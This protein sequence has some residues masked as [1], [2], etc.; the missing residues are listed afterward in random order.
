MNRRHDLV[1]LT[2]AGWHAAVTADPGHDGA[3]RDW[4][5][6]DWPAVVRRQDASAGDAVV[7]LGIPLPISSGVRQRLSLVA[8]VDHIARRTAPVTL[9]DALAAAP[10][11]W[12]AGLVALARDAAGL[13]LR[14]Y[15]SLAMESVTGAP[16]LRPES[17]ID[18]L[19]RPST[20]TELR[21]GLALLAHHAALLPLDGEIV[22]PSGDAVAWKE[23]LAARRDQARVLV[24]S[25]HAVRLQDPALL[26][27]SLPP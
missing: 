2:R 22:F 6:N 20:R 19:L 9:A 16:Y 12:L 7:C 3:L 25:L 11:A 27:G 1:W 18:L 26:E 15:G 17:D 5:E 24:K 10:P 8:H 21:A 4:Y 14:V 23:W 13:D